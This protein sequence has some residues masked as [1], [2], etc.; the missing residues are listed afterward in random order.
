M[1]ITKKEIMQKLYEIEEQNKIPV[2]RLIQKI[3]RNEIIPIEV[4]KIINKYDKDFLQIYNTY[5]VIYTSRNK[6]PLYR[7]L[8][9]KNLSVEE[10]AIAISSLVT[11]VLIS[12]SKIEDIN[13]RMLFAQAMN[14]ENLNEALTQYS[15]Y[16]K[17]DDLLKCAQEIRD[18]LKILYSD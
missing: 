17:S 7:N 9:N 10:I 12:C 18:L 8:R 2:G 1:Q 6:N 15:I 14:I 3:V 11:K 4:I 16:N 13:E 5:N